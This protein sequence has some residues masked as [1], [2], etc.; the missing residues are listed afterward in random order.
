[1]GNCVEGGRYRR[2]VEK[3]LNYFAS[4]WLDQLTFKNKLA[5]AYAPEIGHTLG[6]MGIDVF[7]S[8]IHYVN[9]PF[10]NDISDLTT[11]EFFAAVGLELSFDS[12]FNS[13]A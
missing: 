12:E 8:S 11:M 13:P 7:F 9:E 1:M 10:N 6:I 5:E 4:S 2:D 3:I